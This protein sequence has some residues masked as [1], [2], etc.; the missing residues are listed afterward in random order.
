[1]KLKKLLKRMLSPLLLVLLMSCDKVET[2]KFYE[3][4][5]VVN[6]SGELLVLETTWDVYTDYDSLFVGD[7]IFWAEKESDSLVCTKD[8]LADKYKNIIVKNDR[9]GVIFKSD[10]FFDEN[11]WFLS[12]KN[13]DLVDKSVFIEFDTWYDYTFTI[14]DE[15]LEAARKGG[16]E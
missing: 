2:V 14:T 10:V 1:M 11:K 7:T 3:S 4:W 6:N 15:M 12:V 8:I 5:N 9:G 13:G 16:G